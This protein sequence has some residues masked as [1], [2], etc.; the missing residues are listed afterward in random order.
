MGHSE[1]AEIMSVENMNLHKDQTRHAELGRSI[2]AGDY[3][4]SLR[5]ADGLARDDPQDL[6]PYYGN[7][8]VRFREG[9]VHKFVADFSNFIVFLNRNW[10]DGLA[11][12]VARIGVRIIEQASRMAESF[13]GSLL[14]EYPQD[15]YAFMAEQARSAHQ[16]AAE[17][18]EIAVAESAAKVSTRYWQ[19]TDARDPSIVRT[20]WRPDT[21]AVLQVE[22]TN[23]CNLKCVMCP[24]T[25]VMTRPVENM[26]ANLWEHIIAT[27]S[28]REIVDE[29]DNLLTGGR[30]ASIKRGGVKLYN[31]GEFLMLPDFE[32]FIEIAR[33]RKCQVSVQTNGVLLARKSIRKRLLDAR[34]PALAISIDGFSAESYETVRA[35]SRWETV[36]RGIDAFVAERDAAGLAD[37]I[38]LHLTS[39]LPN[40]SPKSRAQIESFLKTL[41][42]GRL[43]TVFLTL[44][45]GHKTSFFDMDGHLEDITF[46]PTYGVTPDRPTCAEPITKMQ[47]LADGQVSSCCYDPNGEIRV[48]HA[49]QGVD[50]VWQ[51]SKMRHLHLAHLRHELADYEV[52]Q[53]CLGVNPDG[54]RIVPS[55]A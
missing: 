8:L 51:S 12:D 43:D 39:I 23:A 53:R 34:P 40:D 50:S 47:I 25:T 35:G 4:A 24:R 49:S 10:P 2:D 3:Q 27:W 28:G 20:I 1:G 42:H 32:R 26:D 33:D 38:S 15:L 46:R 14:R 18:G 13:F 31:F 11:P 44:S 41:A 52:C 22:P 45:S 7:I 54:T 21:P 17:L 30:L 9:D 48:G 36:K 55:H 19:C 6:L 5:I 29:F 16:I 37:D